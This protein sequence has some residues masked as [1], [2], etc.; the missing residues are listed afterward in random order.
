MAEPYIFTHLIEKR[1]SREWNIQQS[2]LSFWDSSAVMSSNSRI[3]SNIR[4]KA[5]STTS[6]QRRLRLQ[7]ESTTCTTSY[8]P[9][10]RNMSYV[11]QNPANGILALVVSILLVKPWHIS[12]IL[13][14]VCRSCPC[15]ENSIETC[16]EHVEHQICTIAS[17]NQ[18]SPRTCRLSLHSM[19]FCDIPGNACVRLMS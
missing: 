15:N 2:S 18:L 17:S 6:R 11:Y 7:F 9:S 4:D 5:A 8:L 19:S 13:S 10:L 12:G 14:I 16:V 3:S 1:P